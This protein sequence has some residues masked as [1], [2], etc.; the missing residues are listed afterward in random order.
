MANNDILV[1]ETAESSD[2]AKLSKVP[3]V[4]LNF[5]IIKIAA[6]TLGET[7]CNAVTMTLH[8]GYMIGTAFFLTLLVVLVVMQLERRSFIR[9]FTGSQLSLPLR[10]GT[11][12]PILPT[13]HWE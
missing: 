10:P 7:G 8:W 2:Y 11:S 12:W 3:E 1:T 13:V 5:W 6:T 4:T 9:S